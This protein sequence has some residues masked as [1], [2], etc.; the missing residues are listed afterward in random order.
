MGAHSGQIA[1]TFQENRV[2]DRSLR[3]A[4]WDSWAEGNDCKKGLLEL[5]KVPDTHFAC[6]TLSTWDQ[7]GCNSRGLIMKCDRIV[8]VLSLLAFLK[9]NQA[10]AAG[11]YL[12][13]LLHCL[14]YTSDAADEL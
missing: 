13:T 6:A 2:N 1:G 3:Y 11:G 10:V 7:I 5:A 8:I 4:I 9:A 14:L 12:V